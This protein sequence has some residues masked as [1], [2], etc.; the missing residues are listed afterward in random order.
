VTVTLP[1]GPVKVFLSYSHHDEGWKNGLKKALSSLS[2]Q[3]LISVWDD[4]KIPAGHQWDSAIE[5]HL[6]GANIVLLLITK[7]YVASKW[8]RAERD[9]A[10]GTQS[11]DLTNHCVIPLFVKRVEL[12]EGDPILTLQG[13]PRDMKWAQSWSDRNEA[14][15]EIARGIYERVR[16]FRGQIGVPAKTPSLPKPEFVDRSTQQREFEDF[17]SDASTS[18]PSAAQVYLI[19]AMDDDCP[20]Y[21]VKRLGCN[22]INSVELLPQSS[23]RKSR[24]RAGIKIIKIEDEQDYETLE[25]LKASFARD[26]FKEFGIGFSSGSEASAKSLTRHDWLKKY[27]FVLIEQRLRVE[28][29]GSYLCDFLKW[30]F[31]KFWDGFKTNA[32]VLVFVHLIY[33]A[34]G[35]LRKVTARL[36]APSAGYLELAQHL[37]K[38]VPNGQC[39]LRADD[40][41]VPVKVLPQLSPIQLDDIRVWLRRVTE[42]L[43]HEVD[44]TAEQLFKT[45][46][47]QC[48]DTRLTYVV[49][50]LQAVYAQYQERRRT[51][52]DQ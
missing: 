19:P 49:K 7:D 6:R 46:R 17:W 44:E 18:R 25:R 8:C 1:T 22:G 45:V 11:Q 9:L 10:I 48:G 12:A 36:G 3:G 39:N 27:A 42:M 50:P 2:E 43:P 34:P 21:F 47:K 38:V 32:S 15:A 29:C 35:W 52:L 40:T 31:D 30:Y 13:L 26:L 24:D 51:P 23:R 5:A 37:G 16:E 14:M 4:R 20:E 28:R 33:P 41:G